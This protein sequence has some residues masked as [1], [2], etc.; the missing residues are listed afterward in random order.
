MT[1]PK[2]P[3]DHPM[4]HVWLDNKKRRSFDGLTEMA[5]DGDAP[6]LRSLMGMFIMKS[7]RD[8]PIAPEVADFFRQCFVDYLS[9]MSLDEAFGQRKIRGGQPPDSAQRRRR[10]QIAWEVGRRYNPDDEDHRSIDTICIDLGEDEAFVEKYQIKG[11]SPSHT[12]KKCW[13][14][15]SLPADR[16]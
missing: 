3:P 4:Q 14:Q 10:A 13:Q 15:Y 6:A 16:Q 7:E 5:R 12:I 1:R 2:T 8:R 9:G 11:K